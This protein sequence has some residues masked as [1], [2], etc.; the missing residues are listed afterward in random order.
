MS[1][2]V[3]TSIQMLDAQNGWAWTTAGQL[4][5]TEDGGNTW[6]DRTPPEYQ[7]G[8]EGFFL[9]AQNAWLP[10]Y[11]TDSNRFGLLHTTDG[12]Q[13]WVQY[14]QGP[15]SG[16]NFADS[17]HGWAVSADV[18]AGNAFYTLSETSDGGKTWAP[19]PVNPPSPEPDLPPGTIHLCNIC[20]DTLYYD[21]LRLMITYGDLGSM[22][23]TGSVHIDVSFDQTKTW[24]AQDLPLP[25]GEASALVSPNNPVF[26][27]NKDGL[28]P[29]HLL[30]MNPDGSYGEE[31]LILYATYDGGAS[32][33]QLPTLLEE[34]PVF[35]SIA[36][37]ASGDIFTICGNDLCASHDG[38]QS[39]LKVSSDMS[40]AV[41][42]T[43]TVT[44]IDFVDSTTGWLLVQENGTTSLYQT[45]DGGAHWKAL[46][47][48]LVAAA[49][50]ILSVD[51]SVP[52]PSVVPPPTLE[53][54][55]TPDVAYDPQAK[56]DR[57][58]FALDA[59]WVEFASNVAA[60]A[61][62]R[63]V[64]SA[65]QYQT[66]SVSIPEGPGFSVAVAGADRQA[67]SDP[68]N[69]QFYWRGVLPSTQDYYVTVTSQVG[70]PFNLR[71]AINPQGLAK[72][73][74]EFYDPM[75]KAILDY[76]DEFAPVIWQQSF[77]LSGTPLLALY[78]IEPTFYY[79]NSNLIEASLILD[80]TSDPV[81]VSSCTLAKP[82][83]TAIG[84]V[85][86]NGYTFT[87]SEFS[88][89]AAGNR[90]DQ[91]IYHTAWQGTCF[92][93]IFLIHSADIGNY[94]PGTVVAYDEMRVLHKF[95]E[96]I[97]TFTV[98]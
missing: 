4:I 7:Y 36:T 17:L 32:W 9:D 16:L 46:A 87:R 91:V 88:G 5:R 78:F 60:G 50:P 72:Q 93:V 79:P 33:S 67:L 39:W 51:T 71:V 65:L 74:F 54:T 45:T 19:I 38:G 61:E 62:K 40:F 31:K 37:D 69:P 66:M 86:I 11:L 29:I 81:A 90:Y 52:T 97:G 47:P 56:A 42:D 23:P 26:V 83:E 43:R 8:A 1:I 80:A 12:G 15:V 20:N 92:E 64:L 53:P 35:S 2:G 10:M 6:I 85:T 63:F 24:Q 14:L 77:T 41:T 49:T 82:S 84:D 48:L 59:T 89:A 25:Q 30:K 57:I 94:P 95:E 98:K 21:P 3:L 68:N 28:L 22:E 18:G 96:V 55:P 58:S 75:Y 70:G 27:N 73:H 13:S 76:S 44:N 34:V